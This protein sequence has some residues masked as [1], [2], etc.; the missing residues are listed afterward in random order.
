MTKLSTPLILVLLFIALILPLSRTSAATAD[1]TKEE[2]NAIVANLQSCGLVLSQDLT[3]LSKKVDFSSFLG[4]TVK[5]P[6]PSGTV[7]KIPGGDTDFLYI[8]PPKLFKNTK[9]GK[10][11]WYPLTSTFLS[12]GPTISKAKEDIVKNQVEAQIAT[13]FAGKKDLLIQLKDI[14]VKLS[15]IHI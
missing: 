11:F 3:D 14:V 9:T 4:K 10:S 12:D 2:A 13:A 1:V 6:I 7:S 5:I 15:L 8:N